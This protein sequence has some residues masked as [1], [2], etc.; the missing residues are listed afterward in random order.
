[1]MR[2]L[3]AG[4]SGLRNHQIRMDVIGNNIANVNTVGFKAG[5]VNFQEVFSQTIRGASRSSGNRGGSNPM[6]VGL[7]VA[8]ASVDTLFTPGNLQ[9]TNKTTDLAISGEGFFVVRGDN[10]DQYT[11]AGLFDVDSEGYLSNPEGLRVVG[12]M[13]DEFGKINPSSQPQVLRIRGGEKIPPEATSQLVFG[14]LFDRA[15]GY[16]SA[17]PLDIQINT[18]DEKGASYPLTFSFTHTAGT[19]TW[20]YTVKTTSGASLSGGT[21]GQL[22]FDPASGQLS[23][24]T[25][26]PL[27]V[28]PNGVAS[29]VMTPDFSLV[30]Q[31]DTTTAPVLAADGKTPTAVLSTSGALSASSSIVNLGPVTVNVDST[32]TAALSVA[33]T[34]RSDGDWDYNV[35]SGTAGATL[36]KNLGVVRFDPTTGKFLTSTGG[37]L[38]VTLGSASTSISLNW[39]ALSRVGAA[40]V[41]QDGH[42]IQEGNGVIPPKATETIKFAQ[43]LSAEALAGTQVQSSTT[44][45]DH[46]G[47]AH[48]VFVTFTRVGST[49]TWRYTITS[50]DLTIENGE[51][52]VTFTTG[53]IY[54]AD[55]LLTQVGDFSFTPVGGKKVVVTP[56]FASVTQLSGASTVEPD[57]S[58]P[59]EKKGYPAGFFKSFSL[60]AAG[61][62]TVA[63][64]NGLTKPLGQIALANFANPGGLLRSGN[65]NYSDSNNSGQPVLGAPGNNGRGIIAPGSLEMSNVDLSQEFTNMIVTQRGFQANSRIITTSD[66]MLQEL[67][68]LK[69]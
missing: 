9:L 57:D 20:D 59:T 68:N 29:M 50:S 54:N 16:T 36:E 40:V 11:R 5:R 69:R 8:V 65:N 24:V 48:P 67:V 21:T 38:K 32:T 55:P 49:N 31:V 34:R 22:V 39:S 7:G 23:S 47:I 44:V 43:N 3:F 1:M 42:P 60:D 18:Y 62:I 15:A 2:S 25:A 46:K 61:V 56:D 63:Y 12:W 52:Q 33:L 19:D 13:A 41:T 51:G 66:E 4:V 10:G 26:S 45:Y 6:Q 64:T 27:T 28:A 30:G 58:L 53:G 37:P 14:G 35:S 17:S